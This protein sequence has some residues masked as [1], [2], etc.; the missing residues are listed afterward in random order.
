MFI[1]YLL[2]PTCPY[3]CGCTYILVLIIIIIIVVVVVVIVITTTKFR[4]SRDEH[5]HLSPK[6]PDIFR[7]LPLAPG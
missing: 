2:C 3:L 7:V 6:N 1:P 4:V 5:L